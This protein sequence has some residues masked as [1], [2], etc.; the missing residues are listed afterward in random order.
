MAS[1]GESKYG[2]D[3]VSLISV[4]AG[5]F[6]LFM[7][8]LY[9]CAIQSPSSIPSDESRHSSIECHIS[10]YIF[11]EEYK[12]KDLADVTKDYI[13]TFYFLTDTL[14]SQP[15]IRQALDNLPIGSKLGLYTAK[16]FLYIPSNPS[17]TTGPKNVLP[18]ADLWTLAKYHDYLGNYVFDCLRTRAFRVRVHMPLSL[19]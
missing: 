19:L 4:D 12:I 14:P 3:D 2:P 15:E 11:A 13:G 5:P 8:W 7:E 18:T 16:S 17:Y 10:L 9:T 1:T 6:S